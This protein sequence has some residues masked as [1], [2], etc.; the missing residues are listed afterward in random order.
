MEELFPLF[1]AFELPEPL[2]LLLLPLLDVPL[3]EPV[4][5]P[6]PLV[7]LLDV[8]LDEPLVVPVLPEPLWLLPPVTAIPLPI[9]AGILTVWPFSRRRPRL[10][11]KNS[12]SRPS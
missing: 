2:V 7:L 9:P 4:V 12:R 10:Y 8:P 5:L 6:E 1:E 11:L 3:E